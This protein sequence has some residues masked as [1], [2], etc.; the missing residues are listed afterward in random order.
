MTESPKN[1]GWIGFD[2]GGT[3]MLA[4]VFDSAFSVVV[5]KRRKTKGHEGVQSGIARI[6]DTITEALAEAGLQ[7]GDL[8]GIGL[9][10][11]GPLDLDEGIILDAP[12]LGWKDVKIKSILEKEFGC[13]AVVLN[14]VDAGVYGEYRFG[15]ARS[16]RC[17]VGVF[18][19]TGIGGGCVYDG[20]IIRGRTNSCME[21]GH[22]QVV[23]DG[24]LCGCGL[25][26]CLEAVA[27]RLA[28]SSAAAQAAYRGQAP[29]LLDI[30]GTNLDDIRS[31]A[32]ADAIAAGDSVVES[33][34]RLAARHIGTAVASIVHLLAPD[35]VVLG[36]GLVEAMPRLIVNE[37]TAAAKKKVLP[38]FAETFTVVPAE[39]GDDSTA[40][41]AAAW[42][43]EFASESIAEKV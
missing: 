33:I 4:V 15:A 31:G 28:I 22:I 20:K 3:K 14:D 8:R 24:P 37:V 7:R 32:L 13:P 40:M 2:L 1:E 30:A 16:S 17:A 23:P 41:G 9:G 34:V 39:L 10:S 18:P 25:Q 19:G 21:I 35:C 42:V 26:G 12:N 27:S 6:I 5:R 38:S 43:R 29:H 36:G 11:A